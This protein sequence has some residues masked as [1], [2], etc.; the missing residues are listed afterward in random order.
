M[1]LHRTRTRVLEERDV[2]GLRRHRLR[3]QDLPSA[4]C[5][6]LLSQLTS[7]LSPLVQH[8]TPATIQPV[9]D[10]AESVADILG[11]SGISH[12]IRHRASTGPRNLSSIAPDP[13]AL[14]VQASETFS[15][16]GTAL[17]ISRAT[18]TP[19][20]N[21]KRR[22]NRG[23]LPCHPTS[24]RKVA[25]IFKQRL[26]FEDSQRVPRPQSHRRNCA[27]LTRHRKTIPPHPCRP[28]LL[29]TGRSSTETAEVDSLSCKAGQSTPCAG[30]YMEEFFHQ[31]S[32]PRDATDRFRRSKV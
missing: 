22:W 30:G 24:S 18:G 7:V 2:V 12:P 32:I 14:E 25:N 28:A 8:L 15:E 23:A 19:S 26:G 9:P 11:S 6:W 31:P 27:R 5:A 20:Q 13:D 1:S 3:P 10:R 4:D 16:L 17:K 21:R 29:R